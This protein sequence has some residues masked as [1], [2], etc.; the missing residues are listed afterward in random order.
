MRARDIW[1][2]AGVIVLALALSVM[3][4][5]P[6]AVETGA[7]GLSF[8]SPGQTPSGPADS[9]RLRQ[10]GAAYVGDTQQKV[11]Y[12]TFDAGYE[13]GHTEKI[14]DRK[15]KVNSSVYYNVSLSW[16]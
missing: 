10:L 13:N 7:W 15:S 12:L 14:L 11:L 2:G 6:R 8:P 1:I 9:A 4:L 3:G 16:I 5:A